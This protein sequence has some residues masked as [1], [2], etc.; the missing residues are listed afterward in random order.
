M[1]SKARRAAP[2]KIYKHAPKAVKRRSGAALRVPV[3]AGEDGH[4]IM[5]KKAG[6][7]ARSKGWSNGPRSK[8]VKS[9]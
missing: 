3:F 4:E 7:N 9:A 5:A 6:Q 2:H 8:M 1:L